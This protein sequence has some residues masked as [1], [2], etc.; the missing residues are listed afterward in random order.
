MA[1]TQEGKAN[2]DDE[3]TAA[4]RKEVRFLFITQSSERSM[5][6]VLTN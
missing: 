1:P 3:K 4:T 2:E 6:R 5:G